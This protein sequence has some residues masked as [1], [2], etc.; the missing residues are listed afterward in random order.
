MRTRILRV[1]VNEREYDVLK[2]KA[3]LLNKSVS[4]FVRWLSTEAKIQIL[5]PKINVSTNFKG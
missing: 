4:G 3:V 1:R 2:Q 5:P